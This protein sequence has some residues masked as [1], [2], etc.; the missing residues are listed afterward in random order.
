M[1]VSTTGCHLAAIYAQSIQIMMLGLLEDAYQSGKGT[2]KECVDA[3]NTDAASDE[4]GNLRVTM[5]CFDKTVMAFVPQGSW[6][7]RGVN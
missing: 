2:K 6:K 3:L 1:K 7:I 5:S 4:H